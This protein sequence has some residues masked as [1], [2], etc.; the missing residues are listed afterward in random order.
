ME[1]R[2]I[3]NIEIFGPETLDEINAQ[4]KVAAADLGLEVDIYHAIDEQT[5]ADNLQNNAAEYAALVINPSA[6]T[7]ST[8]PLPQ[9]IA[10]FDGLRY[11]VHASNPAVRGVQ[12]NIL[13]NCTGAICGFGYQGYD[14]ALSAIAQHINAQK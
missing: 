7:T 4:I 8:G 12:S 10:E 6:F 14:L 5:V 11:E 1:L 13:P 2:G 9:A 3:E